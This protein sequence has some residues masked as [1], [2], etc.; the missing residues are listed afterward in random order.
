MA[1]SSWATICEHCDSGQLFFLTSLFLFYK[2]EKLIISS[3]RLLMWV[4]LNNM[5]ESTMKIVKSYLHCSLLCLFPVRQTFYPLLGLVNPWIRLTNWKCIITRYSWRE[6]VVCRILLV[7]QMCK[8]PLLSSHLEN[9]L[10]KKFIRKLFVEGVAQLIQAL[11]S[12]LLS[13][14]IICS[15]MGRIIFL[16]VLQL[17]C[18]V[19]FLSELLTS[20]E[21]HSDPAD[22]LSSSLPASGRNRVKK[23]SM[24]S[25]Y[26]PIIC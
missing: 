3:L 4:K 25:F 5:D 2:M 23:T 18:G 19:C 26:R 7:P 9:G 14:K 24:N 13:V 21:S 12:S 11:Q 17:R 15:F 8:W 16:R 20:L 10:R 6:T 1:S 22:G